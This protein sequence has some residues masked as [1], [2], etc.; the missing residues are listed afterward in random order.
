MLHLNETVVAVSTPIG[1]SGIA[2]I[3]MTGSQA[4]DVADRIFEGKKRLVDLKSHQAHHGQI[5][6]S[7]EPI[8]DVVVT[9]FKKPKSYTGEDLV[10]ISCHGGIYICRKIL[11]LA[12]K[13]GAIPAEPGEF[14]RRAFFNGKIDLAQAEAVADLIH[15]KTETARRVAMYQYKGNLSNMIKSIK[16]KLM[17]AISKL[18]L[19]LDF[20]EEDIGLV[21]KE[22]LLNLIQSIREEVQ[23][24]IRTYDRGRIF[25]EG[26]R[27]VIVGKPNVGKSSVL[28]ALLERDRA[29]VTAIPGTTRDTVEDVMDL[30]GLLVKLIDTAGIHETQDPIEI[31]GLKRT[32]NAVDTADLI[33][34][35]LDG[36]QEMQQED[37]QLIHRFNCG[38]GKHLVLVVNK[39]DLQQKIDFVE[40][41]EVAKKGN[42]LKISAL[43]G[44]NIDRL[45]E[46]I[47][48]S[49]H[50]RMP[51]HDE[52]LLTNAR[53]RNA[54]V[55]AEKKLTQAQKSILQNMSQE[56][57]AL[58]IRGAMEALEE[59]LG[60][61]TPEDILNKI[62][63][64]FCI[65]K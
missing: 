10:E 20:I 16:E 21:S 43:K 5:M 12:V 25:R 7:G 27:T 35:I 24:F 44:Y 61:A 63:S 45:T 50:E 29:I 60:R 30:D 53:H 3:R 58:D 56:F 31:E 40:I 1:E 14:T 65:G 18:E 48:N 13:N 39:S 47:K 54:L 28:N 49:Y 62:F 17:Q 22:E 26:L 11:D 34:L 51:C 38:N 42:C 64:E 4:V 59:I 8:D 52:I 41:E 15:A 36:S 6:E 57:I 9:I 55:L 19:E 37:Q 46:I 23:K 2:V 33:L 32:E